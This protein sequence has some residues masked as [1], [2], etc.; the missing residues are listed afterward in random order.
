MVKV[1]DGCT[2]SGRFS[3]RPAPAVTWTKNSE[4]VKA[5]EHINLHHTAHHLSLN[6]SNAKREHSGC[7]SVNVENA[8]GSRSGVCTITVVGESPV[9]TPSETN[10]TTND[11]SQE[12]N[13]HFFHLRPPSASRGSRGFQ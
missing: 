13:E 9:P 4:E 12:I 2:V 11:C 10:K 5:D 8:A 6:V 7:Y 1:G 3:G